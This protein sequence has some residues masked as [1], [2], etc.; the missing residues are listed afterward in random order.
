MR[1]GVVVEQLLGPVPGGTGRY[2]YELAAALA[3]TAPTGASVAGFVAWHRDLDPGRVTGVSG[4][5]RLP[6]G[7][8]PLAVCWERGLGPAPRGVDVVLAPTLL[9]PP[10]RGRPLL[11]AVHDAVPWTH[12]QTL[13][14]RG[15]SFHRRAGRRAAAQADALLVPTSAVAAELADHLRL[16]PGSVHVVGEGVSAAVGAPPV[17]TAARARRLGLPAVYLLAV[18]TLEPRKGLDVLL[19]ALA[20][21]AAPDLPL[22]IVGQPGWGGVDLGAAAAS[23]GLPPSRVREL[24]RLDDPDLATVL[25]GATALAAPSRAEGFGLPVLEAMAAGVPV[26]SSD[27]PALAEVADGATLLVPVNDA[28][29]LALAL[30]R[31]CTDSGLRQ[32]LI[33]AGQVRAATFT[34][35]SAATRVWSIARDLGGSGRRP[36]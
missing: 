16:R 15:V 5:R 2:T 26:V 32:R 1:L 18:A 6:V 36:A 30:H 24:G 34:W 28:H 31:I 29:A 13:T 27:V 25:H 4:P 11:V 20:D 17:D 8:R 19:T 22:V 10:R 23:A 33:D 14:P 3:L 21:P 12:P 7:R 35:A 9:A